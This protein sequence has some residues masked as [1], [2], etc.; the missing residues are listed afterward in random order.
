MVVCLCVLAVEKVTY[1]MALTFS[2]PNQQ[3]FGV[4]LNVTEFLLCF[5]K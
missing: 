5:P 3:H 1:S 2:Q 4:D